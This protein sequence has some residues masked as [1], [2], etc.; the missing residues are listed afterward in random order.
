[1][2]VSADPSEVAGGP[3]TIVCFIS[4]GGRKKLGKPRGTKGKE[5]RREVKFW[6]QELT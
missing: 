4:G 2:N 3:G 6:R 1:M 5:V